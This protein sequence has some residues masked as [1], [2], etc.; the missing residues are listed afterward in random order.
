MKQMNERRKEMWKASR[1]Q[2]YNDFRIFIM[3]VKGNTDLFGEGVIYEDV[4]DEPKAFRGQTGAQDDIIP[5]QDIFSGVIFGSLILLAFKFKV[6]R[7]YKSELFLLLPDLSL[8]FMT[9]V[10]SICLK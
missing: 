6:I 7:L 5:M 10:F 1:W 8:G 9:S 3:G 4:W 2:R